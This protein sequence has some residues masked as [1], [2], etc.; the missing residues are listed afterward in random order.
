M[1]TV[2]FVGASVTKVPKQLET[3]VIPKAGEFVNVP[4]LGSEGWAYEVHQVV[5]SY[6]DDGSV[7]AKVILGHGS[8]PP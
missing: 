3:D 2:R 7:L 4:G 1:A 5:L 8:M 6:A